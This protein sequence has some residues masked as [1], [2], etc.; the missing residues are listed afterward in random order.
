[1]MRKTKILITLIM[2]FIMFLIP[3]NR[4]YALGQIMSGADAF[5]STGE[6]GT[7]TLEVNSVKEMSNNILSVLIPVGV[8]V[9][10]LIAA[11]LGIKFMTGSVADQAKVKET[12]VPYVVGCIIIFGAFAIWELVIN[13]FGLAF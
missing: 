8:I 10:V 13:V 9:A 11:Y 1:M 2:I 5:I 7:E 3:S 12:L 4:S 6:A